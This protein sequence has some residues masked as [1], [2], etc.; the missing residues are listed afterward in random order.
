[1]TTNGDA[2]TTDTTIEDPRSLVRVLMRGDRQT[3]RRGEHGT[4]AVLAASTQHDLPDD[5]AMVLV[6]YAYGFAMAL[7]SEAV[8]V[9]VMCVPHAAVFLEG[10]QDG[11]R[12]NPDVTLPAAVNA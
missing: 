5:E 4:D 6:A 3:G 1:M 10:W 11:C 2:M 7:N 9:G 8:D 12:E